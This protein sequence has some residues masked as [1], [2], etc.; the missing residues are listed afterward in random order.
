MPWTLKLAAVVL[1]ALC[2]I[3]PCGANKSPPTAGSDALD[4]LSGVSGTYTHFVEDDLSVSVSYD[5]RDDSQIP[6]S[7]VTG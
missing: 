2:L 3:S 6:F 4:L 1:L 7:F 5:L